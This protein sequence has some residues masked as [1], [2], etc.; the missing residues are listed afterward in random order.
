MRQPVVASD[1]FTY[2]R[3][4]IKHV[5]RSAHPESPLT[6]EPL[7]RTVLPNFTMLKLIR[8]HRQHAL[9]IAE[10]ALARAADDADDDV[11]DED[12][13]AASPPSPLPI[14]SQ[15]VDEPPAA[16]AS[17]SAAARCSRKRA[18][19]EEDGEEAGDVQQD[20]APLVEN[21]AHA[22]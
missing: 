1:G 3:A 10:T 8:E 12:D 16:A 13:H 5:L 6:R 11:D 22:E 20:V 15:L 9:R 2:E 19:E 18:R 4:A 14:S 7:A 17:V 21:A